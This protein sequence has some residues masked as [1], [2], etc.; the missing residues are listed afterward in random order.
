MTTVVQVRARPY[1]GTR[2]EQFH[3]QIL[4]PLRVW[5]D[6]GEVGVGPRPQMCVLAILLARGGDPVS[7]SELVDALWGDN[8]PLS[9][10]NTV[11]K[12]VGSLRRVLEPDLRPRTP[13]KWLMRHGPGYRFNAAPDVLDLCSFRRAAAAARSSL[14]AGDDATALRHRI[15][16]L[17]LWR[18]PT[19]GGLAETPDAQA[20]FST[21]DR[22]YLSLAI[23]AARLARRRRRPQLVLDLLWRATAVGPLHEPLHAELVANLVLAGQRS[24]ALAAYHAVRHRLESELGI[25]PSPALKL[26]YHQIGVTKHPLSSKDPSAGNTPRTPS[27]RLLTRADRAKRRAVSRPGGRRIA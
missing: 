2:P 4:G 18:G 5:R 11:H 19:G 21:L 3:F 13:G 7:M 1:A 15:E 27:A 26:A 8:P 12:Y 10:V 24:D 6:G 20:I 23:E 14:A 17:Q 16:A 25:D 9:A 22:E